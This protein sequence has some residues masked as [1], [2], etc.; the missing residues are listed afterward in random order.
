MRKKRTSFKLLVRVG[1]DE[2]AL[3]SPLLIR[4]KFVCTSSFRWFTD[5][6]PYFVQCVII[7]FVSAH[8]VASEINVVQDY[9]IRIQGI[10][11]STSPRAAVLTP[12][13]CAADRDRGCLE[14]VLGNLLRNPKRLD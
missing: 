11:T 6:A 13:P 1:K 3:T 4:Q 8:H 10:V 12:N 9:G 2:L 5:V 14:H 7:G